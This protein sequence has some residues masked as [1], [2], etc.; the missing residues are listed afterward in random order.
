M[1][2][3]SDENLYDGNQYLT[4]SVGRELYGFRIDSVREVL[5]YPDVTVIPLV[6]EAVHGVMNL[7]GNVVTIIDLS[8]RLYGRKNDSEIKNVIIAET[9]TDG[10]TLA[11]GLLIDTVYDVIPVSDDDVAPDPSFG[12]KIPKELICGIGKYGSNFVLLLDIDKIINHDA[13][14]RLIG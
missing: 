1:G 14:L 11:I 3:N 5:S 13:L 12:A 10:E 9:E 7:R 6:G 2:E 8:W 4:F